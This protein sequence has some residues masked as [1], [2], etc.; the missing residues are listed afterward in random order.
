MRV[1]VYIQS[2]LTEWQKLPDFMC[3]G[4]YI[5]SS[6][7]SQVLRL[8]VSMGRARYGGLRTQNRVSVHVMLCVYI[9]N[10]R[11]PEERCYC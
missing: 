2:P 1:Y 5:L 7:L 11:S 4:P 10:C 9:C 8:A 3:V 6:G